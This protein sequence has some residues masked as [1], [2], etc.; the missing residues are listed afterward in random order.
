M[1]LHPAI[2]SDDEAPGL[3]FSGLGGVR[4]GLASRGVSPQ[5]SP[6]L[7]W[8]T[9]GFGMGPGGASALSATGAPHPPDR[10]GV[11]MHQPAYASL[12]HCR[13]GLPRPAVRAPCTQHHDSS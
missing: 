4:G 11:G 13:G 10:P 7:R 12:R 3:P 1:L 5:Y 9:T 8:V 6:A 2:C